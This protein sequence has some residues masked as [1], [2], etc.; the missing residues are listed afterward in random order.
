MGMARKEDRHDKFV[1]LAETRTQ[2]ALDAIRL[3]GNLSN[4]STYEF[5]DSE[6]RQIFKA[7]DEELKVARER[8]NQAAG[9][10]ASGFT[11]K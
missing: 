8:F 11:L 1:R 9:S 4:R 7:L 5:S 6:I 2:K 3:I 10:R